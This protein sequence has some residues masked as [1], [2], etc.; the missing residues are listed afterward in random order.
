MTHRRKQISH[1]ING[2]AFGR[3]DCRTHIIVTKGKKR[4]DLETHYYGE[5][6]VNGK[7]TIADSHRPPRNTGNCTRKAK[8][9]AKKT[10]LTLDQ[11]KAAVRSCRW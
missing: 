4:I 5:I 2:W 11:V 1:R 9:L 3:C 10:G 6:V 8:S 7:W